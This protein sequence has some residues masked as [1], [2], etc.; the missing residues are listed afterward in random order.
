MVVLS[1][2]RGNIAIHLK[3]S[4]LELHTGTLECSIWETIELIIF[5]YLFICLFIY[6]FIYLFNA[7]LTF[8]QVQGGQAVRYCHWQPDCHQNG[9]P[10]HSRGEGTECVE[11]PAGTASQGSGG[12]EGL[13]SQ[14][15]TC[16][17]VPGLDQSDGV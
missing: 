14:Y 8:L 16:G 9:D 1:L 12:P 4:C 11:G 5:I 7:I 3:Y 15:W 10:L 6:L 13:G 2:F 17:C